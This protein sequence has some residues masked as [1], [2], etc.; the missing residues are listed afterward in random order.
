[1]GLTQDNIV[2]FANF[3]AGTSGSTASMNIAYDEIMQSLARSPNPPFVDSSTFAV[4]SGTASYTWSTEGV[5]LLGVFN[6]NTQLYPA[7]RRELESYQMYWRASSDDAPLAYFSDENTLRTVRLFPSPSTGS[8]AT[9]LYSIA[10]QSG[11]PDYMC[12]YI[13]FAILEREFAYPSAHQDK[14]FS[15]ICGQIS[16]IFG[17]LI[18]FVP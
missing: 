6:E 12:L 14:E 5:R 4:S 10:P 11:I 17:K 18:G 16:N 1:M 9:W 3:I 7:S 15:G 8:T 13:A 2:D